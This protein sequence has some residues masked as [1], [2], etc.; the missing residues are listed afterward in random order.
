MRNEGTEVAS[1]NITVKE[2]VAKLV[3]GVLEGG[4]M[5]QLLSLRT[6]GLLLG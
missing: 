6:Q 2:S 4:R 5:E 1:R 3:L